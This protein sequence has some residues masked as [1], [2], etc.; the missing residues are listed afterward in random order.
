MYVGSSA[1]N[2]YGLPPIHLLTSLLLFVLCIK[3][4]PLDIPEQNCLTIE[5][6]LSYLS[7]ISG[8]PKSTKRVMKSMKLRLVL[9][10]PFNIK[11]F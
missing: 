3:F 1:L 7:D 4:W 10:S 9:A 11:Y 5:N 8:R 2:N 6:F